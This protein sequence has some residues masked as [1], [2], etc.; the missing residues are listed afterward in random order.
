MK[1]FGGLLLFGFGALFGFVLNSG[2]V[3]QGRSFDSTE[4][5]KKDL[6]G[7]EGKEVVVSVA[8]AGPGSGGPHYHPGESF[9]YI[10]DGE[11]TREAVGEETGT[12]ESGDL[13][14]DA[15]M[16]VHASGND[17]PVKLLIVRILDKGKPETIRV[18]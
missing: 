11:Q 4:L 18:E 7:C 9:I 3:A 15:R 13:I 1:I 5:I 12:F 6:D 8:T 17:T 10:L 16:Q 2:A 14:Y